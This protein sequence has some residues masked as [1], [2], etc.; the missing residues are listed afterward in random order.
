MLKSGKKKS[1]NLDNLEKYQDDL[2]QR[3]QREEETNDDDFQEV[4]RKGRDLRDDYTEKTIG[5]YEGDHPDEYEPIYQTY[6]DEYY[7]NY[8]TDYD[9][10]YE[11]KEYQDTPLDIL[12][13]KPIPFEKIP[14]RKQVFTILG[15]KEQ[16][17]DYVAPAAPWMKTIPIPKTSLKDIQQQ[18]PQLFSKPKTAQ[19]VSIREFLKSKTYK[20]IDPELVKFTPMPMKED[21]VKNLDRTTGFQKFADKKELGQKLAKTVMCK[22]I[23]TRG[24][25]YRKDCPFAH[26]QDEMKIPEC[27]FGENCT[28]KEICKFIHPDETKEEYQRRIVELTKNPELEK[29]FLKELKE[30]KKTAKKVS[31][32]KEKVEK[33]IEKPEKREIIKLEKSDY[34][35]QLEEKKAQKLQKWKRELEEREAKSQVDIYAGKVPKQMSEEGVPETWEDVETVTELTVDEKLKKAKD[36][37]IELKLRK[38]RRVAQELSEKYNVSKMIG[39]VLK[40]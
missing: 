27:I 4:R 20:K 9:I 26:S 5:I 1:L 30:K 39:A 31:P 33:R 16:Q 14:E 32:K 6:D 13:P 22:N 7:D 10:D 24:K 25:C 12:T 19:K 3:R 38:A 40:V 29:A 8:D 2:L 36:F 35:R 17:V 28:R 15:K 37:A 18:Q 21:V 34:L 11:D 23:L